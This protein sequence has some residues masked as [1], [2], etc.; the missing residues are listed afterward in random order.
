MKTL[1]TGSIMGL[2]G[3]LAVFVSST[4]H[5]PTWV[6]FLAWV[7]YYLFGKSLT[8][9]IPAFIQIIFGM[10]MGILIQTVGMGLSSVIG[11]VG[12]PAAVFLFI[13]SLAFITKVK[14]L[15]TIP[16][17]FVGLIIFFGVHPPI[18]VMPLASL[19][20]P[21]IFG[22]LFAWTNDAAIRVMTQRLETK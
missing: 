10:V 22:F 17:W 9:S 13:G 7:S 8:T 1:V 16:A 21:I 14:Q 2:F 11:G 15:S 3:A 19:I 12:F 6:M 5:W 18:A 4:L 20:I